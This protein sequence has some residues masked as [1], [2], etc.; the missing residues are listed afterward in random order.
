MMFSLRWKISGIFVIINLIIGSVLL[1]SILETVTQKIEKQLIERGRTIAINLAHAS[2]EY[3]LNEDKIALKQVLSNAVNFESVEYIL[4]QDSENV[5]L[6]KTFNDSIPGVIVNGLNAVEENIIRAVSF[7]QNGEE[8]KC[9]EM[10]VAVEE[11]LLGFIRIG[12]KQKYI[13]DAMQEITQMIIYL[14]GIAT[15][16][17]II[18]VVL[19]ANRIISPIIY[20][21]NK[22]NEISQGKL[23]EKIAVNTNDEI[24]KLGEALERLRESVSIALGRL[25]KRQRT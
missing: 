19:F 12:M 11:G 6:S 3:I 1:Y 10:V 25:K 4:I 24:E 21:T 17:G 5:I 15:I 13:D 20:L 14:I 2:S 7:K 8:V 22:A 16:I 18:I 9:R 23:D